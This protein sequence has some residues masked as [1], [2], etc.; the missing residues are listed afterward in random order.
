MLAV[1]SINSTNSASDRQALNAEVGQLA[2]ELERIAQSSE[3]N[4]QKVLNGD[5]SS[6]VFQVGANANQ[7]I[8]A[9]T[10][11]FST[12]KY[13]NYR[14]GAKA[15]TATDTSGDLTL[16][17][18]VGTLLST[19]TVGASRVAGGAVVINGAL[20]SATITTAAGDTAK[21]AATL[22][23][24]KTNITGVK[25]T[26]R[27]EIDLAGLGTGSYT[28]NVTSDNTTTAVAITFST[29]GNT[30]DGLASAITAFNER[31]STTGVTAKL[32]QA[33]TGIT[34]TNESG[35]N[36][37]IASGAG[38]TDFTVAGITVASTSTALA[39]GQLTLDSDKSFGVVGGNSTDF[40]SLAAS[41]AVSY[42]HLTLPTS[43]LV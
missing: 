14:M 36:I 12:S 8:T 30:A 28:L 29:T 31:A 21:A 39:T 34:L 42:T 4:G 43:D 5:I 23:N 7:T 32:N 9:T 13:G 25:A 19:A 1:Q 33:K 37:T 11:N 40:F 17:T 26:A 24:G 27:T 3:F 20:G 10:A 6:A 18:T 38:N 2:S 22:I 15:A 16:G 35:S 41:T